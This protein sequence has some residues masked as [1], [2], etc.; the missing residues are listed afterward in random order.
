LIS[1]SALPT[2]IDVLSIHREG[3]TGQLNVAPKWE[4]EN[5]FGTS[6]TDTI[7]KKILL[8][9]KLEKTIVRH[10]CLSFCLATCAEIMLQNS[11]RQGY[12]NITKGGLVPH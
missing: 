3:V 4:L 6:D 2:V 12:R 8:E 10:Q 11:E 9:G 7:I 5:E 1:R